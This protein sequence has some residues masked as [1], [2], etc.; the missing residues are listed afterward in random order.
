MA[1]CASPAE[2]GETVKKLLKKET[3]PAGT[4]AWVSISWAVGR[5]RQPE[6]TSLPVPNGQVLATPATPIVCACW[7][8]FPT[9]DDET[10]IPLELVLGAVESE[11]V[12]ILIYHPVWGVDIARFGDDCRALAKRQAYKFWGSR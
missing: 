8:E 10:V 4:Q 3:R 6:R 9:S 2:G 12:N 7:G 11:R 1:V 5:L